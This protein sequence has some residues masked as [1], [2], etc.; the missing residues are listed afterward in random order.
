MVAAVPPRHARASGDELVEQHLEFASKLAHRLCARLPGCVDVEELES[1]AYL[2]LLRA[3][4][5]FNPDRGVMFRTYAA[6][7]IHGAML[8]GLRQRNGIR[9]TRPPLR[10]TSLDVRIGGCDTE[11]DQTLGDT[12]AAKADPVGSELE[13]R[14]EADFVLRQLDPASRKYLIDYHLRGMQQRQMAARHGVS[15]SA[16]SQR[17]RSIRRRVQAIRCRCHSAEGKHG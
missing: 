2:G 5:T 15:E 3:A 10:V 12:I 9:R 16:I 8:D 14:E 6:S 1:D 7:R 13:M 17:M 11:H 4:R